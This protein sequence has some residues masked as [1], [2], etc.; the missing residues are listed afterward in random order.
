MEH[1]NPNRGV[2]TTRL[3]DVIARYLDAHD[4]RATP[5]TLATF[6]ADATVVDEGHTY[7]GTEAIRKWLDTA[8]SEYTYTRT[9]LDA[10]VKEAAWVLGNR[11]EGD[12]PG[13]VADLRF[14]FTLEDGLITQLVIT[15]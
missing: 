12:F 6:A 1:T 11:L 2:D 13:N 8:A 10:H 14:R 15:P 7:T 3:P 5:A 9:L 4:R